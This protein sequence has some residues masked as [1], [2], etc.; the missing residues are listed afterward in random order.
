V[1]AA[2]QPAAH[3][4]QADESNSGCALIDC[5]FWHRNHFISSLSVNRRYSSRLSIHLETASKLTERIES[6]RNARA[7]TAINPARPSDIGVL[8]CEQ[9]WCAMNAA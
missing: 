1:Q 5:G 8:P 3:Q 9:F 4:T 7:D 2:R 6:N